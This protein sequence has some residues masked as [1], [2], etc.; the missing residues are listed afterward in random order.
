MIRVGLVLIQNTCDGGLLLWYQKPYNFLLCHR[1][2][3]WIQPNYL[4]QM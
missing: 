4:P 2:P 1:N 3:W